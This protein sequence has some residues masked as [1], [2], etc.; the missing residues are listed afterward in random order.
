M[1]ARKRLMDKQWSK[2]KEAPGNRKVCAE[3]RAMARERGVEMCEFYPRNE[4]M[5]IYVGMETKERIVVKK[6]MDE[7]AR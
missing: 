6:R 7:Y 2:Q 4:D 3:M 1:E 5:A